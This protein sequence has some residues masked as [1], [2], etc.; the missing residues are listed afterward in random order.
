MKKLLALLLALLMCVALLPSV[1]LADDTGDEPEGSIVENKSD[2]EPKDSSDRPYASGDWSNGWSWWDQHQSTV[3]LV[4]D[5]GCLIVAM[6]KMLVC[7]DCETTDYNSFNPDIYYYWCLNNGYLKNDDIS[8]RT[9]AS[10]VYYSQNSGSELVYED[11]TYGENDPKI[12]ENINAGKFT[13]LRTWKTSPTDGTSHY[14]FV[15]NGA[16]IETGRIRVFQSYGYNTSTCPGTQDWTAATREILTYRVE[17]TPSNYTLTINGYIN[18]ADASSISGYGT[19]DLYLNGKLVGS[20]LT[21]Y[22]KSVSSGTTYDIKLR[23]VADGKTFLGYAEGAHAGTVNSNTTARMSFSPVNAQRWLELYGDGLQTTTYNNHT[24]YYY[25]HPCTWYAAK[26]ICEYLGGHL[27]TI[28]NGY[29]NSVVCRLSPDEKIWLGATDVEQEGTWKWVTGEAFN[30][31]AWNSDA[32]NNGYSNDEGVENYLIQY[33]HGGWDDVAGNSMYGFVCEFEPVT[34]TFNANGGSVSPTSK[35]V[36]YS[37]TYGDLPTPT[38]S[39]YSFDGWY[40]A[41]SGGSKVTSST[42]VTVISDHTLYAHWTKTDVTVTFDPNGGSV[43]PSSKTVTY[44]STYG[45]LPTPTREGYSFDGWFTASEGGAQ[46]TSATKVTNASD[47]TLHAHWTTVDITVTFDPNGG[48]VSPSSKTVTYGSTYGTLPTPTRTGYR[49]NGWYT[50]ASGGS[51]VTSSTTVTTASDHTLYAHWTEVDITVTFDP[52]GGSVST[53]SKT[54]TYGSTYGTLP[55]P[56]RTGYRFNGWYTA[57]EGGS[58]VTSSTTV[59]TASNHTLYAHWTPREYT[60]YFDPNGGSIS[61]ISKKVTYGEAYGTLPTPTRTEYTFIGWYTAAIDGTPVTSSTTVT[62]A[63]DHTLYAHW[64]EVRYLEIN[65]ANFPDDTFRQW[66]ISNLAVSGN[67]E[68]GYYM[69]RTQVDSVT[70]IRC[71]SCDI[72]SLSGIEFFPGLTEL[73][74]GRNQLMAIDISKNTALTDLWCDNNQLT[75]LDVSKNAGLRVL[76]CYSNQLTALD[77]SWNTSLSCLDCGFNQLSSLDVSRNTALRFLFCDSNCLTALDVG[78]NTALKE[79]HCGMNML[80]ALNVD[81]N[82]ALTDLWCD[83]NQLTEL[84]VSKNTALEMLWCSDNRISTLDVSNNTVLKELWCYNNHLRTLNL[85]EMDKLAYLKANG[86][87]VENQIGMIRNNSYVYDMTNLMSGNELSKVTIPDNT[88][89]LDVNTGIVTFP[90][91]TDS[92]TY[93]YDTEKGSM[94]VTVYLTFEA[95]DPAFDGTIEWNSADVQ[96]KGTT[97]YVIAN[98]S[99]QRPR[100]TVKDANGNTVNASNYTYQYRENTN[101]GTGYVIVTFSGAYSGTAQAWFKIYLPA[102]TYTTVENVTDGIRIVWEPVEGAAGYVIYRRAWSSTTNGW[103]TFE[104]WNNTTGTTYID[105]TDA[106]HKVYAGTRYQYGVKAYFA[107]RT[108]PVSG[109]AIGGNVGD[110]YNLGMVGPLKTTVRITTRTLN[111]VTAGS[112]QMTVKWSASLVFTGYQVQYATNSAFTKGLKT[113]KITNPKTAQTV[114]KSLTSS[115]TYYVRVR[116]YHE[117]EGMT[118]YGGWSNVLSCKVK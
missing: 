31:T 115:K 84:N 3:Q 2:D 92:F 37:N 90:S 40:T 26:T 94:D 75:A 5:Y 89:Q 34:V 83:S 48:S 73:R 114:I 106:S 109:A 47:H 38:H 16:S 110:N 76:Y 55:T 79:F 13:I 7:S 50:A 25:S 118:Y 58:K 29:D 8:M 74:C 85:G 27:A 18:G 91:D 17:S 116:S 70:S 105:G 24:Y 12:W 46:V 93:Q 15:N 111:S 60:V 61:T 36:A 20:S 4:R 45:T 104:R 51:Q 103:T 10:P 59:T 9:Y 99:A 63:S 11:V 88:I 39:G 41:S 56:T 87:I 71:N 98:G 23:S 66:I 64:T 1:T 44:G 65:A 81:S 101:A 113:V 95:G 78:N 30:H 28:Y 33:D 62:T 77:V 107:R 68:T 42:T 32:P 49:F 43:S 21:S 96:Y 69:T 53:S 80:T 57:A 72:T 117:F 86:Q 14:V 67:T 35:T 100:F 54:V 108:D 19:F 102:T 97:P 6:S 22:S 112:N 82:T 52:N